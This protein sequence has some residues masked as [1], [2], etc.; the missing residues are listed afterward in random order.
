MQSAKTEESG[1]KISPPDK[2]GLSARTD[3]PFCVSFEFYHLRAAETLSRGWIGMYA[4]QQAAAE[5]RRQDNADAQAKCNPCEHIGGEVYITV[6]TGKCN[7]CR[8][9]VCG[10]A[11]PSIMEEQRGCSCERGCGVSGREGVC[12]RQCQKYICNRLL[13]TGAF[14]CE[15][16]LEKAFS[17]KR[18][19]GETDEHADSTAPRFG[20][21][22]QDNAKCNPKYACIAQMGHQLEKAIEKIVAHVRLNPV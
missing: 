16:M 13:Y 6:Q 1:D 17:K 15:Q 4:R 20:E 12:G 21:T 18:S 14:P 11:R 5:A 19:D 8:K 3:K 2:N 7:Q 22:K 9:D 10:D